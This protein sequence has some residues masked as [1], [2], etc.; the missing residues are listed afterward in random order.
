LTGDQLL[1]SVWIEPLEQ[2]SLGEGIGK[3]ATVY[4]SFTLQSGHDLTGRSTVTEIWSQI[5]DIAKSCVDGSDNGTVLGADAATWTGPGGAGDYWNDGGANSVRR[6]RIAPDGSTI[7]IKCKFD[8]ALLGFT[9]GIA[10][11]V[12][13]WQLAG[14][15]ISRGNFRS[16]ASLGGACPVGGTNWGEGAGDALLPEFHMAGYF[17]TRDASLEVYDSQWDNDGKWRGYSAPF[18]AARQAWVATAL[19]LTGSTPFLT[20]RSAQRAKAS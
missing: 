1:V 11:D 6:V 2:I 19:I 9:L 10:A 15:D 17:S 13:V 20:I 5:R 16:R 12:R 14:W 8:E 18:S 3:T 7:E 4:R